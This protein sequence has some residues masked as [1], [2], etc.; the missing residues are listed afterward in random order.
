[1]E[2]STIITHENA[3]FDGIMAVSYA[4][5]YGEE[6][7]PG[8][9]TAEIIFWDG[10]E[11]MIND[12]LVK[13]N[14]VVFVDICPKGIVHDPEGG[15]FV[16]DHHPHADNSGKTATSKTI[17]FLKLIGDKHSKTT[18]MAWRA[19]FNAGGDNG[20]I[21]NIMKEMHLL[22]S[23]KE[24]MDWLEIAITAFW[25]TPYKILP[26]TGIELFR[27]EIKKFLSENQCSAAKPILIHWME[28][29][30]KSTEDPM[31]IIKNAAIILAAFGTKKAANWLNTA[32]L[33]IQK[34]QEMGTI[35]AEKE[36][37]EANKKVIGKTLLISGGIS[38]PRF[39]KFCRSKRAR[40]LLPPFMRDLNLVILQVQQGKGFQIFSD[41][42]Y[43]LS[44]V[45]A[46]IRVEILKKRNLRIPQYWR[47]REL[48]KDGTLGGTDPLYYH[49]AIYDAIFWGAL[50]RPNVKALIFSIEEIEKVLLIVIDQQYF[51]KECQSNCIRSEC[52]LYEWNM[53]R[54][55][56]KRKQQYQKRQNPPRKIKY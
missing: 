3:D 12:I 15:I 41:G 23:D 10:S 2:N 22:C 36:F 25:Q 11:K 45:V 6:K 56:W 18:R 31:S 54:C 38:N 9:D 7:I 46:A 42:K 39:N 55:S 33:A 49:D 43:R 24:V 32:F 37:I 14:I 53:R 48:K 40:E 50:T 47:W 52:Q 20:N 17:E 5:N 19:D 27:K 8:I 21:A 26:E 34:G 35:K 4:K 28:K 51:P 44:D 16:F 29:I 1:M 30:G 13:K